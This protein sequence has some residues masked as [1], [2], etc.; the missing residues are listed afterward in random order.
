MILGETGTG[1]ELI[2]RAI[3][4]HGHRAHR[5]F[6]AVNCAAIPENLLESELFGHEKGAFTG[7]DKTRVGRFEQAHG[8]TLFLDEIGGSGSAASG[9]AFAWFCRRSR[10]SGVG[11]NED[12]PVDVRLIAATHHDLER[13]IAEGEFR[14]DLYYR[15][16]VATVSIPPLRERRDDIPHL[17]DY[18]LNRYGREFGIDPPSIASK[19]VEFLQSQ[20]WP[21]NIRQLQ[22]VIRKAAPGVAG[23]IRLAGR[24]AVKS[25]SIP[26]LRNIDRSIG[27]ERLVNE[28]LTQVINGEVERPCPA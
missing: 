24:I 9:Q 27:L 28:T 8:G 21:G 14:A 26:S 7:A 11:S 17:I 3:Y 18:F 1:K 22:N 23:D 20:D 19:A 13:S 4:Q 6:V 10:F 5:P 12:I 25:C 16:N 2:A 15:L